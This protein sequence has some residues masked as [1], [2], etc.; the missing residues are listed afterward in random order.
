[1]SAYEA[2]ISQLVTFNSWV[3]VQ[4][5]ISL[6]VKTEYPHWIEKEAIEERFM[7]VLK[8]NFST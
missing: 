1:M 8:N 4:N 5:F 2:V 7:A 6:K 3:E